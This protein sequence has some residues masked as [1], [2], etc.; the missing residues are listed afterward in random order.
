MSAPLPASAIDGHCSTVY[1]DVLYVLSSDSFQSLPLAKNA[2][3]STLQQGVAVT[4]AACVTATQGGDPSQAAMYVIGGT[5]NSTSFSGVQRYTFANKTWETLWPPTTN[6]QSRTGHTATYLPGTQS[7]LVFAGSQPN[8]PSALSS[9]T[10]LMSISPP[11]NIKSYTSQVPP[12]NAPIVFQWDDQSAGM[13]GGTFSNTELWLF[14]AD[15]G[16]TKSQTTLPSGLAPQI[17]GALIDTS[18]GAKVLETYDLSASPNV[19]SHLVLQGAGGKNSPVA[20]VIGTSGSGTSSRKRDLSVN[21]WPAYNSTGAPTTTRSDYGIAQDSSGNAVFSGGNSQVPLI[22]FN[23]QKNAWIDNGLFF[24]EKSTNNQIPLVSPSSSHTKSAPTTSPTATQSSAPAATT[25]SAASPV[26]PG[27]TSKDHML[28]ILG[29]TLGVLCGL[30]AVFIILLLLYRKRKQRRRRSRDVSDE[31]ADQMSFRDRGASFMH[32]AGGSHVD[33]SRI[34]PSHRFTEQNTSHN[35]FAMIASKLGRRTSRNVSNPGR[36]NS[37]ESTRQLVPPADGADISRPL[38][39]RNVRDAAHTGLSNTATYAGAYPGSPD[40]RKRSSGWSRYF[41]PGEQN[42]GMNGSDH[43]RPVLPPLTTGALVPPLDFS[44]GRAGERLSRVATGS[45]S[46]NHSSEDLVRQGGHV[47][48]V[49]GQRAH[50][51]NGSSTRD[52]HASAT[53][54]DSDDTFAESVFSELSTHLRSPGALNDTPTSTWT[55]MSALHNSNDG[56]S[57]AAGLDNSSMIQAHDDDMAR[58]P[59][60]NYTAS[61]YADR[62]STRRTTGGTGFFPNSRDRE[63]LRPSSRH[64]RARSPTSSMT[65]PAPPSSST[66]NLVHSSSGDDT[67]IANAKDE[68]PITVFPSANYPHDENYIEP[69]DKNGNKARVAGTTQMSDMSWLNLG[70]NGQN[71]AAT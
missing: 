52:D 38:E 65:F 32:E 9:Q 55:P 68:R 46:F 50:L 69:L 29:I 57:N 26:L 35:S 67:L 18:D 15:Q 12:G 3:W 33:I 64:N 20:T 22:L 51:S 66:N 2:T 34:P 36:R 4:G 28:K 21:N 6:L 24:D 16:W 45:P 8:A 49:R 54:A 11:Y 59:S 31:K 53:S 61:I 7:I 43:D 71:R 37:T 47:E 14:G 5:S 40:N 13:V 41:A 70:F 56:K 42:N 60:S 23:E 25:S 27:E 10:F 19:I 62:S 58:P 48:A 17:R 1:D 63:A 39:L 44:R 30:A